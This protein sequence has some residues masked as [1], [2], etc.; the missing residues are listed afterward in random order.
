[1]LQQSKGVTGGGDVG[2]DG[3][4]TDIRGAGK[5]VGRCAGIGAGRCVSV[6]SPI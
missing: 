6:V 2:G 5:G 1:M 3:D 4:V